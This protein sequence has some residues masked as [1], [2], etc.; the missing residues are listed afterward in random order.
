MISSVFAQR[1]TTDQERLQRKRLDSLC[2]K[3]PGLCADYGMLVGGNSVFGKLEEQNLKPKERHC[4]DLKINYSGLVNGKAVEGCYYINTTDGFVAKR[5]DKNKSCSPLSDFEIGYRVSMFS[6]KGEAFLF[7]I[8]KK[9]N[10]NFVATPQI[11][12]LSDVQTTFEI[13]S[14]Y[15]LEGDFAEKF[16]DRN[17]PT[18]KYKI[19]QSP[20]YAIYALFA[21]YKAEKYE[22]HDY[23]GMYGTGFYKDQ[24]GNTLMSLM[25]DS[26]PENV[27]RIEKITEVNE[28]FDGSPFTNMN[29]NAITTEREISEDRNR[30]LNSRESNT[31]S[32]C[33]DLERQL[34]ALERKIQQKS[35]EATALATSGNRFKEA[36]KKMM[37]GND[38]IDQVDKSIL[39]NKITICGGSPK[40][41][42]CA[43]LKNE[44]LLRL[45]SK[46]VAVGNANAGNPGKAVVEKNKVYINGIA[47]INCH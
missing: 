24:Y 7:E 40:K 46:L 37:E 38:V 23:L 39:E 1:R 28:C 31:S 22:V 12:D 9:K 32:N 3:N 10:Y 34:I 44:Q 18:F 11:V 26:D 14:V 45:R 17:L 33:G 20:H 2:R 4:F 25:L 36:L 43:T 30:D 5:E 16:T 19:Q 42:G 13:V 6:M 29:E 27:I 47:E 15:D 21:P 8:D 41:A 35:D